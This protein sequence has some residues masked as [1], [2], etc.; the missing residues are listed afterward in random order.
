MGE[1]NRM[2][3]IITDIKDFKIP[4]EGEHK[5]IKPEGDIHHCIGCWIKTPGK[6]GEV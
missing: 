5:I 6:R 2:K 4:V 1:K 3:L